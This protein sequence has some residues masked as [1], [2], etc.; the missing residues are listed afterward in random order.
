MRRMHRPSAIRSHVPWV[1]VA[2]VLALIGAGP[3]SAQSGSGDTERLVLNGAA[4]DVRAGSDRI[5]LPGPAPSRGGWVARMVKSTGAY[6]RPGGGRKV[7]NV[8][9]V[10][11]LTGNAHR[12]M[13][14]DARFDSHR[15]A[16]LRVRLP[17]RPNGTS[18]WILADTV[19]LVRTSLYVDIDLSQR[20]LRVYRDGRVLRS[21]R[22]VVGKPA[23]PTPR[24]LHAVYE[25]ARAP[26]GASIGPWALHLTAHSNVLFNYGGGPGRV[27]IHGR[28][29]E[30]L[31]APLGT[32][33][34]NGCIRS[35]NAFITWMA[36][37]VPAG[38]PVYVHA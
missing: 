3:A 8:G 6:S 25:V 13:V 26:R 31:D 33:G 2:L 19:A 11:P 38:T 15:R 27:A 14:L 21:Q 35:P 34:S 23:T 10:A 7:W 5:P 32:A 12:L 18:G 30:L 17:I 28:A 37:R 22:V 24:G 9:A 29:G 36:R 20:R 4:F 16:W 1:I